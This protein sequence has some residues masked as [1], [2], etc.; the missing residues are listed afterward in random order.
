MNDRGQTPRDPGTD[1]LRLHPNWAQVHCRGLMIGGALAAAAGL[2]AVL[3]VGSDA[4]ICSSGLGQFAQAVS[5]QT[6]GQC[7]GY[8]LANVLGWVGIVGGATAFIA[9]WLISIEHPH[10][11][12]QASGLGA[13]MR[14][15]FGSGPLPRVDEP[16]PPAEQIQLAT[17]AEVADP[18]APDRSPLTWKFEPATLA[19]P[20]P[21]SAQQAAIGSSGIGGNPGPEV[22]LAPV[23]EDIAKAPPTSVTRPL[24]AAP[25]HPEYEV[26]PLHTVVRRVW[27][28]ILALDPP[29]QGNGPS[30]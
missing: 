9:G 29:S 14:R 18:P 27:R 23:R 16:D 3:L 30:R 19:Q 10:G 22:E 2:A 6:A 5:P 8:T 4:S 26:E 25:P 24:P 7:A 20:D 17:R 21:P 15:Q 11:A 13:S 1:P 12:A 28:R